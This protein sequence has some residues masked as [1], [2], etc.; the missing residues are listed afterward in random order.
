MKKQTNPPS[1]QSY[2][3][4]QWADRPWTHRTNVWR[5]SRGRQVGWEVGWCKKQ[6]SLVAQTTAEISG[7]HLHVN[8]LHAVVGGSA[9]IFLTL[10][11]LCFLSHPIFLH[12][13]PVLWTHSFIQDAGISAAPWCQQM[14]SKIIFK[15]LGNMSNRSYCFAKLAVCQQWLFVHV[16]SSN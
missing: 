8:P 10:S 12:G 16:S 2:V 4:S 14:G 9:L 15:L 13:A 3:L 1:C 11:P 5:D 6:S 7:V